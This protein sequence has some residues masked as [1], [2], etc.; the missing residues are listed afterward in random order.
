MHELAVTES[1]LNI[2][3][4]EAEK[5]EA[6]HV[7]KICIVMGEMST[8]LPECIQEY[9]NLLSEDTVAHGALLEFEKEAAMLQCKNCHHRFHLEHMQFRCPACDSLEVE[10]ISGKDFYVSRLDLETP[11]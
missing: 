11:D 10:I 4:E 1:I 8:F 6:I 7:D 5:N 3:L 2:A 9:F